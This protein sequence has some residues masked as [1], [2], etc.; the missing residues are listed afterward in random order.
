[1]AVSS[2]ILRFLFI[3]AV[4]VARQPQPRWQGRTIHKNVRLRGERSDYVSLR[5]REI[6]SQDADSHE[7]ALES[8][9]SREWLIHVK[10]PVH[11]SL[12]TRL[13]ENLGV[14][15]IQYVPHHTF[16]AFTNGKAIQ[17]AQ[18]KMREI[19]WVGI[20]LPHHKVSSELFPL[21]LSDTSHV[22]R[23][24]SEP[25]MVEVY[26][27]LS[28]PLQDKADVA[29]FSWEEKLER[30]VP[31]ASTHKIH[32]RAA[33]VNKL[34]IKMHEDQVPAALQFL[35]EQHETAWVEPKP[36]HKLR[37]KWAKGILQSGEAGKHL[38]F[39]RGL[40]GQGEILGIADTGIDMHHCFFS[41]SRSTPVNRVDHHHRKVVSY[42][43]ERGWG[44]TID[45]EGHGSHTTGSLV[46]STGHSPESQYGGMAP[47]GKLVMDDIFKDDTLAP[48]D[49]LEADLFPE[50]YSIGA[51]IRSESWGGDSMFYTSSAKETDSFS[52][53][54]RDFLAVWAAGN[55]GDL[56][57]F[58]IGSPATAKN[59]LVV[60]AQQS[61]MESFLLQATDAVFLRAFKAGLDDVELLARWGEFGAV[62]VKVEGELEN[63]HPQDACN[64]ISG[65]H[66][67]GKIALV[68]RGTCVFTL[69]ARHVQDAGAIGM[70]V[71]DNQ[72]GATVSMAGEE[73]GLTIPCLSISRH[74]GLI[75]QNMMS[76]GGSGV[77]VTT[78][79]DRPDQWQQNLADFSGK[80]PT[81]DGRMMP[82]IVTVGASI[83]S[84]KTGT[85]CHGN[86]PPHRQAA[87]TDMDGTS[88][89]APVAAGG[90]ALVR[91]YFREGW[92]PKG[93]KTSA[94]G[95]I[96]SGA[97]LRATIIGSGAALTG[98]LDV[99]GTGD[100][101]W[102]ELDRRIPNNQQGY[103]SMNLERALYF[104]QDP[105][106]KGPK[107]MFVR[108]DGHKHP[109]TCLD[110][111]EAEIFSFSVRD[112]QPFKVTIAWTDYPATLTADI[113]LVNDLDLVVLGPDE[114]T[115]VGNNFTG[116]A[117][118]GSDYLIY[119]RLN[120]HEQVTVQE[121]VPGT[122]SV[123]IRGHHVP[124]GPQ[125]YAL[126]ITGDFDK[127]ANEKVECPNHCSGHGICR[128][129]ECECSGMFAGVDCG[130]SVVELSSKVVHGSVNP[131]EWDY[132]A[133]D[134]GPHPG[135]KFTVTMTRTSRKGDPD[136][137]IKGLT[138]PDYI[139]VANVCECEEQNDHNCECKE[140]SCDS[141]DDEGGGG[142]H[143]DRH[144][145]S[146][147]RATHLKGVFI[148]GIVGFCCDT[149][150]YTI[151]VQTNVM[152]CDQHLDSGK[153]KGCDGVCDSGKVEDKCGVCDG[154]GVCAED[155]DEGCVA[156]EEDA[157]G[158]CG[159]DGE[160]CAGCDGIPNSGTEEDA[161]GVCA[162]DG[163]SCAGCDGVANSGVEE[164]ECGECGGDGS[165][166]AGCDGVPGSGAVVDVCGV[167]AGDNTTCV[168]CDGVKDS[169]LDW[170]EC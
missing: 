110:T 19:V 39:T 120:N 3:C 114:R 10:G 117:T 20:V 60:G 148:V 130:L 98:S 109:A 147:A 112:S 104:S 115:W 136:M 5:V 100:N 13:R 89:A 126:I 128:T 29:L 57:M 22:R 153:V 103:G 124:H 71:Y 142:H 21:L 149:A 36:K 47:A 77:T 140:L 42:R 157:C 23:A 88:M 46:G 7:S 43:Y 2:F 99:S 63:A 97:L 52:R 134:L 62:K 116:E 137:Y 156:G 118:D 65:H 58:T 53:R 122:Y 94:D 164:D 96:P 107:A 45:E 131:D 55:D 95:F 87:M 105:T 4:V 78:D 90:T 144:L 59:M 12:T 44:N 30:V 162:G 14:T 69:K 165:T 139:D 24:G 129:G 138:V 72:Y 133:F 56:G 108:D 102:E 17:E 125:C 50:P 27:M 143:V 8:L 28:R 75:I 84:A 169:G 83:F 51:R 151:K 74:D 35:S 141:C 86:A 9:E 37:N 33:S 64:A 34:V 166:C 170:D 79:F 101:Q 25:P 15:D 73:P 161:C 70:L 123:V 119:D 16:L 92:Y 6:L 135:G 159:G 38:M 106:P 163:S 40:E 61:T 81:G 85:A 76:G 121:P 18:A 168:G 26:L 91:Q 80:G 67:Q 93:K 155:D 48:P 11:S 41:D 113:V 167:C 132:F 146:D 31:M 160:S 127:V 111:A 150:Q 152:G 145:S 54:H 154:D 1:M 68:Q 66:L 49:D 82:H 32:I 158:V